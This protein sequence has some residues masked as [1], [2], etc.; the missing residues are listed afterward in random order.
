MSKKIFLLLLL[1]FIGVGISKANNFYLSCNQVFTDEQ[2]VSF[3]LYNYNYYN[4]YRSQVLKEYKAKYTLYK[5][6]NPL[7]FFNSKNISN[8]SVAINDSMLKKLTPYKTWEQ[9]LDKTNYYTSYVTAGKLPEGIY[10]V[11][12]FMN[13]EISHIPLVVSNWGIIT[14]SVNNHMVAYVSDKKSG[15]VITDFTAYAFQGDSIIKPVSYKKGVALFQS[16]SDNNYSSTIPVMIIK[17]DKM[18]VNISYLYNYYYN[19]PKS[20][21]IYLFTDQSAYRPD[22]WVRFKGIARVNK[23][24]T[25]DY[26]VPKGEIIYYSIY[27]N[28]NQQVMRKS[29]MLDENGCFV[30]SIFLEKSR[31]LGEYTIMARMN[32]EYAQNE[33]YYNYYGIQENK[34]SFRLEEFKKPEF[35]VTVTSDK[36]QYS[37]GDKITATVQAKYFFGTKVTNADVNWKIVRETIYRPWYYG[38]AYSWWYEDYYNEY[39]NS[40]NAS[41]QQII[42]SGTGKLN[43][44]GELTI[45]Y[46]TGKEQKTNYKYTIIADVM[47]ASRRTISGTAAAN[48]TSSSFMLSAFSDNY[49]YEPDDLVRIKTSAFDFNN[50]P[51]DAKVNVKIYQG[52]YKEDGSYTY[53][54]N[55]VREFPFTLK[56]SDEQNDI[57]FTATDAGYYK[58][59]LEAIDE[60]QH[61]ISTECYAYIIN[62]NDLNYRWWQNNSV[63]QIQ[64]MTNKKVYSA[65]EN[66]EAMIYI[67]HNSN[68]LITLNGQ[69]FAYY[70]ITDFQQ[71]NPNESEGVFRKVLIPTSQSVF[72]KLDLSVAYYK[73]SQFY[74]RS[75]QITIIPDNQYLNVSISYDEQ[76]YKP[77]DIAEATVSVTDKEGNPVSDA[78]LS[79]GIADESIYSLYGDKTENI[80]Q[81]FYNSKG[82]YNSNYYYQYW[83]VYDYSSAA[84]ASQ[85]NWRQKSGLNI[86]KADILQNESYASSFLY[87]KHGKA[88]FLTG[89]VFDYETG[90]VV[91]GANISLSG[92]T[93]KSDENGFFAIPISDSGKR[94]IYISANGKSITLDGLTLTKEHNQTV[95][96][97]VNAKAKKVD[98]SSSV[99]NYTYGWGLAGDGDAVDD[100]TVSDEVVNTL[101]G[102]STFSVTTGKLAVASKSANGS[103]GYDMPV[104]MKEVQYN[105]K[106]AYKNLEPNAYYRSEDQMSQED[107]KNIMDMQGGPNYKEA[108]VRSAFKDQLA[109]IPNVTTNPWGKAIISIKIPD[110][111]TT[112]RTNVKVITSDS[113]VGESLAKFTVTKNLLVRMETPRFM[114]LGDEMIIATNIHNY[115]STEKT[116]KVQL[117]ADGVV[118]SETAKTIKIP[119]NGEHRIDWHI[120]A[121]YLRNAKLT[122]KALTDEESD[123]MVTEVPVIPY[124]LEMVKSYSAYT[125]NTSNSEINFAIDSKVDLTSVKLELNASS[126]ITSALLSSMDQLIGYP[127]GCVEQTMSRFLPDVVVTKTLKNLGKSYN[128]GISEA[129]LAKMVASGAHRLQELQHSDGGWGWWENDASH[130]FM[131]AYAMYGLHIAK[132]NGYEVDNTVYNNGKAALQTMIQNKKEDNRTTAAY[133]QMVAQSMG[134]KNLWPVKLPELN[135]ANAYELALW[136]QAACLTQ[137]EKAKL[138]LLPMLK[139]SSVREGTSVHWGG[140]R[141]HYSWEEDEVETSANAIRAMLMAEPTSPLIPAAIQWLMNKRTGNS[142][143]NTRETAMSIYALND[144]IKNELNPNLEYEIFCNGSLIGKKKIAGEEIYGKGFSASLSAEQVLASTDN[145]PID[146]NALLHTGANTID[147]KQ[148]GNGYTYVN[149][150]LV[151]YKNGGEITVAEKADQPFKITRQYFK[152]EQKTQTGGSVT[153]K[154]TEVTPL[155]IHPGDDILVKVNVIAADKHDYILMEDPIPAGCEFVRDASGYV[156][157]GESLQFENPNQ[158]KYWYNWNNWYTHKEYRDS[159]L[160][161]TIT[162]L[163]SGVYTYAYILKAEIPGT[164]NINPSVTQLMYYPEV[165]GFSDFATMVITE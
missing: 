153:Y 93:Y 164:F 21:K 100:V 31:A 135:E 80:N 23:S 56:A 19:Q 38:Y 124:G 142:W 84:T 103:I 148:K 39:Y 128:S 77:G 110:N 43:E 32:A 91:S 95:F 106:D 69:A 132:E 112:W 62:P 68:A 29:A 72:G 87:N 89:I 26:S 122:V 115:L 127:Y 113:K 98:L 58:I 42:Q 145:F 109:W 71:R 47:D 28:A 130:P 48:V 30:D 119:A 67:P 139:E 83:N 99:V 121:K 86:N 35:E 90:L 9:Q 136:L 140:K 15:E 163:N 117:E 33:Y 8:P 1:S 61:P 70:G 52:K 18:T 44:K 143:Y 73:N 74:N 10:V 4:Y 40:I 51:V 159:H 22:N 78:N 125:S 55:F 60:N 53:N 137:D 108:V 156:I 2:E 160:A 129:E 102:A 104:D 17:G 25:F 54:Y 144:V 12:A 92:K 157:D 45:E 161:M 123:A 101:A 24:S 64:I 165:R 14:K 138:T 5:I 3:Y 59:V 158:K 36:S 7:T 133:M 82:K 49:Y 105:E 116:V 65:G 147:V 20:E 6:S 111:L 76:K 66:V 134:M 27:D 150:K 162:N 97:C 152:L 96:A 81:V 155:N 88:A 34:T 141:F 107:L 11:E 154:K 79:F 94:S 57:S 37:F 118:M 13:G 50:K 46:A 131:T 149:A 75:E 114:T 85:L 120:D 63:G 151:Y 126:S 146:E 16:K 41:N